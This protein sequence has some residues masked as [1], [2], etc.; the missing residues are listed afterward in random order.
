VIAS[1]FLDALEE[2]KEIIPTVISVK[3]DN[4]IDPLDGYKR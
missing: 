4:V 1:F 2:R 3:R